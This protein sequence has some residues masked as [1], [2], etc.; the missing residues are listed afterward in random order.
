MQTTKINIRQQKSVVI[1]DPKDI[2]LCNAKG[3]YTN[4]KT[5]NETIFITKS[6]GEVESI[7]KDKCFC[8]VHQSY[9]VNINFISEYCLS[10]NRIILKNKESI[11]ISVRKKKKFKQL[12]QGQL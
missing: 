4:M 8:R 3:R 5:V 6:I 12:I 7:L 10:K 9:I 11:N 2:I 1:V